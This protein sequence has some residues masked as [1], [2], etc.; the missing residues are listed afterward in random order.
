MLGNY[1]ND[2]ITLSQLQYYGTQQLPQQHLSL[3]TPSSSKQQLP[4]SNNHISKSMVN[5]LPSKK[6]STTTINEDQFFSQNNFVTTYFLSSEQSNPNNFLPIQLKEQQFLPQKA[7]NFFD[8]TKLENKS[9]VTLYNNNF[10][11]NSYSKLQTDNITNLQQQNNKNIQT[12]QNVQSQCIPED[13]LQQLQLQ[14]IPI[15]EVEMKFNQSAEPL[16]LSPLNNSSNVYEIYNF[17]SLNSNSNNITNIKQQNNLT[18]K[19]NKQINK[20]NIFF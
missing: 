14:K 8:F 12:Q 11:Q 5:Y 6:F 9:L 3:I 18:S 16:F 2:F 19:D 20:G 10:L 4:F 15:A 17:K 1:F 7:S 13:L